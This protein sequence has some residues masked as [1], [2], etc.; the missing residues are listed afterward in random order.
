MTAIAFTASL[1]EP[2]G[3]LKTELFMGTVLRLQCF[4]SAYLTY[5]VVLKRIP[6]NIQPPFQCIFLECNA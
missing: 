3:E 2:L 5:C 6:N 4:L 1:L